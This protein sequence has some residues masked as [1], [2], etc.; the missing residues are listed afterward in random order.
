MQ[1]LR[2]T[3]LLKEREGQGADKAA[4]E[5]DGREQRRR[6]RKGTGKVARE[7][8]GREQGQRQ[9]KGMVG[10]RDSGKGR[11]QGKWQG[12]GMA[13]DRERKGMAETS[14]KKEDDK[15]GQGV[16]RGTWKAI[17]K[18]YDRGQGWR[19]GN[20]GQGTGKAGRKGRERG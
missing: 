15:E 16:T 11:K 1:V 5:E 7:G 8:D 12:K 9:G 4:R 10:N 18:R 2:G 14:A 6:Q 19:Q 3:W 17:R 13:V 20:K